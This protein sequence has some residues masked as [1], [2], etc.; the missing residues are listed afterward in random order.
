MMMMMMMLIKRSRTTSEPR[1]T[2]K[3]FLSDETP[4]KC[5][6]AETGSNDIILRYILSSKPAVTT[7]SA[8]ECYESQKEFFGYGNGN[9]HNN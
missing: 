7:L 5:C 6:F 2:Q 4:L 3:Q 8:D 9:T 1:N